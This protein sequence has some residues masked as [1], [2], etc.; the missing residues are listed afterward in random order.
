MLGRFTSQCFHSLFPLRF[1]RALF[2]FSPLFSLFLSFVSFFSSFFSLFYLFLSF[3]SF[4]SSFFCFLFLLFFYLSS[5]FRFLFLCL[6]SSNEK[7]IRSKCEGK[8]RS[9]PPKKNRKLF[10]VFTA[11]TQSHAIWSFLDDS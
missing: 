2:P 6:S 10:L 1:F 11:L 4:F 8:P 5:L 7:Y 3:F 9:T